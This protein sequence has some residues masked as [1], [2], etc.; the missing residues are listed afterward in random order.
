MGIYDQLA[1]LEKTPPVASPEPAK[2]PEPAPTEPLPQ[3]EKQALVKSRPQPVK[4]AKL[5]PKLP[6]D[7]RRS[8]QRII[9][10]VSMEIYQDQYQVLK[11]VSLTAQL[12]GDDLSMSEMVREALDN[13]L[14]EKNLTHETSRGTA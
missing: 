8:R 6:L 12:A 14:T 4:V 3:P 13:Y 11:Q 2:T 7:T 9:I 5:N 1:T 10:R